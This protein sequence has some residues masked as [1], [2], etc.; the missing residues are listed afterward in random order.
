MSSRERHERH[1]QTE[2]SDDAPDEG[3]EAS[4]ES[5]DGSDER[6]EASDES[7]DGSD[8]S[9]DRA[10]ESSDAETEEERPA[11]KPR[12]S[13]DVSRLS[14]HGYLAGFAG[15]IAVM[16]MGYLA[17]RRDA[18]NKG[19]GLWES[20][21]PPDPAISTVIVLLVAA[22]AMF[23]VE[24]AIR[25]TVDRG[26]VLSVPD[27]VKERRIGPFLRECVLVYVT[28]VG[29]LTFAL[30]FYRVVNEYGYGSGAKYYKP[31]LTIM[32]YFW[33]VYFFGGLPYVIL[34]RALQHDPKADRKQLA[35]AVFKAARKLA[36]RLRAATSVSKRARDLADEEAFTRYDKTA[37]LGFVVKLFF[38]PV[39]TV[40]FNDQFFHLVKNYNYVLDTLVAG[41]M[42]GTRPRASIGDFYNVAFSVIFSIDVGLAWA[43]YVVSSRWIKNTM[44]SVEPT[45][46]GW[47]VALLSYPPINRIFG[48]YL[49]TPGESGFMSIGSRP[50]VTLLAIMS[51]ASFVVYTSATVCFGLRFSN[52]THRGIITT[53]PY[54]VVRHP[55]YAA[56]NFS[57]WCVMLPYAIYQM[58]SQRSL[59]QVIQVVGLVAMSSIYYWRALTEERHLSKDPE[60]RAYMKKVPFR[61]IPGVV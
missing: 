59:A 2:E 21:T 30:M 55:A 58:A 18:L 45:L 3:P 51:V 54:S 40:F 23:A 46:L 41:A 47:T 33:W 29:I 38:V 8:E 5:V 56:K 10:G 31:W 1:K 6:A 36:A 32:D 14:R 49:S 37:L 57:W 13:S 16:I 53:G 60:Y 15:I 19:W 17:S 22:A 7:A 52:L 39:M 9:A 20:P 4:E 61:F 25:F 48:F 50:I 24:L 11:K 28:E 42:A 35:F 44:Y 34:T 43:G 26:R 27:E 12:G